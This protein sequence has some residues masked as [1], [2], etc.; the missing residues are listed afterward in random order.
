M[1]LNW[2]KTSVYL[3]WNRGAGKKANLRWQSHWLDR[4][5]RCVA[6]LEVII[7]NSVKELCSTVQQAIRE[8]TDFI[9]AGGGDGTLHLVADQLTKITDS[10]LPVLAQLPFGSGNDFLR[11]FGIRG[12]RLT[13]LDRI[14]AGKASPIDIGICSGNC[15]INGVGFG[16]AQEVGKEFQDFGRSGAFAYIFSSIR[17]ILAHHQL[18]LEYESDSQH[19][20][21]TYSLIAIGNSEYSGGGFRLTPGARPNDGLLDVCMVKGLSRINLFKN[22]PGSRTGTHVKKAFVHSFRVSS[23][24]IRSEIGLA[25]QIDGEILP[26]RKEWSISVCPGRL[27]FL[28]P[29]PR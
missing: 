29:G 13:D 12:K 3:I 20:R 26:P 28:F 15:F 7:P 8:N 16:L 23:L 19:S 14:L 1:S 21:G 4:L 18:A 25:A 17:S 6:S 2:D 27:Q 5:S 10:R 9:F 11:Q 22:I 24:A